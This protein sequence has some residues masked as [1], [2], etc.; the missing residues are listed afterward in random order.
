MMDAVTEIGFVIM[1]GPYFVDGF[2][3][4]CEAYD[5]LMRE[6]SRSGYKVGS[7]TTR[8]T[9][10]LS[11]DPI[12]D[13]V[14]LHEPLLQVATRFFGEP[15]KLSSL[16]ARTLRP[17]SPAQAL[18]ADLPRES[19]DAP[20]LGFILMID[21][22]DPD[23]GATRFVPGSQHWPDVPSEG[24]NDTRANYPGEV[25]ACGEA[26]TMVVFNAAIWHGHTANSTLK[27]RRSIQGYFARR[28]ATAGYEF[29]ER[30]SERVKSR[31]NPQARC[32]LSL[33]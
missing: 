13:A 33:D 28:G 29:A 17:K 3:H 16:L 1:P 5:Q 21:A 31:F 9:D 8:S 6:T 25:L 20:L 23:N 32:L 24:A 30:L 22:F 12:F 2:A 11:S 7:S 26:G 10:V 14:Y 19:E 18:H 15:F 4:V 27:N